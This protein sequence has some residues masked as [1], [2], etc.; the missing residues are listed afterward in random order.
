MLRRTWPLIFAGVALVV[1]GSYIASTQYLVR[2]IRRESQIH[3]EIFALVQQGLATPGE[4]QALL[5]LFDVQRELQRLGVPVVVVNPAGE[6]MAA[7][8]V[9][10]EPDLTDPAGR[11]EALAFARA[12]ERRHPENRVVVD[13]FGAFYFGDPPILRWLGWVPW[14]QVTAGLVLIFIALAILRAEMRAERERLWA[15]MARELA[16]QM[17]TPL[18]S[19]AGWIEVLGLPAEERDRMA[20]PDY[21]ARV[22]AADVE[23]LERVS[24]R[25]ELIGKPPAFEE[26]S[27][28]AV[29][30]EIASYFEPRLPRMGKG[31]RLRTRV[32][33]GLAPV[34]G[35]RVLLVWA[36]ENVVKNAIDALGGR[37]GKITISA[38]AGDDDTVEIHITDNGPGI[39]V[40]VRERIFETGV[41]TKRG[42]WG[43]GLALTKRIIE[44]LHGGRISAR[45]RRSGGTVFDV[46][47]P[48]SGAPARRWWR[49]WR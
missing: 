4:G 25:F 30:R 10:G 15:A 41:S 7:Q 42:G 48:Y 17:G 47:V 40:S 37:G 19:L 36:L 34:R 45:P 3:T 20:E 49:P 1:F 24:R 23:R 38:H 28:A 5:A 46:V 32:E 39:D 33:R 27:I 8:N 43:V 22:I 26:V 44:R 35:N 14:L 2:Q 21:I 6:P 13:G 31:I 9:P 11:A 16:H 18:S 12:L 29:I